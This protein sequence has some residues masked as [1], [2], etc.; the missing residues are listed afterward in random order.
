[1]L[2]PDICVLVAG[3]DLWDIP[4]KTIEESKLPGSL[5]TEEDFVASMGY[6]VPKSG[7]DPIGC[8]TGNRHAR[9]K[10]TPIYICP[11]D[12][13]S[14]D[15]SRD[16]T[17]P[18]SFYCAEWGCETTRNTYWLWQPGKSWDSIW[19]QRNFTSQRPESHG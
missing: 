15:Q 2:N 12:G 17:G 7:S 8:S 6:T 13:R 5:G 16:C 1:M 18:E 9:I 14:K 11:R 10:G 4:D 19:V 3:S